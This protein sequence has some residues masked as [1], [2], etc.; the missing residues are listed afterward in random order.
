[1]SNFTHKEIKNKKTYLWE[2][3]PPMIVYMVWVFT[4]PEIL[5]KIGDGWWAVP[6]TLS[7]I[8]PLAF[9]ARAMIRFVDRC[10]E[11]MKLVY[12]KSA[13][14]SLIIFTFVCMGYGFL[15]FRGYP[16]IP[17]FLIGTIVIPVYFMSVFIIRKKLDGK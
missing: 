2:F 6:L 12:M 14:T 13:V 17:L 1:M 9:V 11:L 4:V 15:E 10:D 5:D 7:Q 8:I 16:S 3:W